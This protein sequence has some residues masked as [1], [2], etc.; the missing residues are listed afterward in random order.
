MN[1]VEEN[2][3]DHDRVQAPEGEDRRIQL[4]GER[5]RMLE[6]PTWNICR[7][8]INPKLEPPVLN[9]TIEDLEDV[10]P[11]HHDEL[12]ITGIVVSCHVKKIF[13][14]NGSM[15]DIILWD[16]T[17]ANACSD[18]NRMTLKIWAEPSSLTKTVLTTSSPTD[19]YKIKLSHGLG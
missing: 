17:S 19:K 8:I 9:F 3:A 2:L 4:V 1:H 7:D 15:M 16:A 5:I 18:Q 14:D 6:N 13:V 11:G 10:A 12:V